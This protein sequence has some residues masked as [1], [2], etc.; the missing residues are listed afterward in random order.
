VD[1]KINVKTTDITTV[2][3][4]AAVV[5]LFEDGGKLSGAALSADR[6]TDGLVARLIRSGEFSGKHGSTAIVHSSS[7]SG[8]RRILVVGLGEKREFNFVVAR[9][10]S[11]AAIRRAREAGCARVSSVILGEGTGRL[12]IAA[13]AGDVVQGAVLGLY[14]FD[15]YRTERS[16]LPGVV[17]EIILVTGDLNSA[18]AIRRG[19]R[20]GERLA[21][22]VALSRDLAN[23]PG[24]DL[25]PA[26]FASIS[27]REGRRRGITVSVFDKKRLE[28]EGFGA[29]LSVSRGSANPPRMA[30]L[31]YR[32][33]P[34]KP[35]V[36]VG[37]GVT[38]DSGGITLKPGAGMGEM[39]GDMA[40]AA[41]A[42]G[43]VLT[44]ADWKLKRRV[45]GVLPMAENMPS[46]TASRPGDVVRLYNGLTIE[47]I[48]TDA[49]GRM[50]LADAL[51]YAVRK[52]RPS[53]MV[54]IATLTGACKIALGSQHA[55]L[56]TEHDDLARSLLD[57]GER[58]GESVWQMPIGGSYGALLKSGV[59][60][61]KHT[62][63]RFGGA[64]IAA[65]FLSRFVGKTR[66]AH[67]DIAGMANVEKSN[68]PDVSKGMT[69]FGVRLVAEWIAAWK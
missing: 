29:F 48:S 68:H 37:K 23:T 66:W 20:Q 13:L 3:A 28:R 62:G 26:R 2:D 17:K 50:L 47:I 24:N 44:A 36:V 11:A 56:F 25:T 9:R 49:E 52:Y 43:A 38:F 60:D 16:D 30:V 65:T 21:L 35:I 59:A 41:A 14:L 12:D 22:N 1:V 31:D 46:G 10:A 4:D 15:K 69:G 32:G 67:L 7:S 58:T 42:L 8:P 6:F 45:I 33:G 55:G 57:A 54:D 53:V 40:G 64:C 18:T 5:G 19:A 34:G 61:L 63:G 51:A 39:K 27:A